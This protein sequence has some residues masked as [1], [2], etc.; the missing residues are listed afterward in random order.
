MRGDVGIAPYEENCMQNAKLQF[1][2]QT[3]KTPVTVPVTGVRY[4]ISVR[5]CA[6]VIPMIR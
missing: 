5:Y 6:G 4:S 1:D 3:P 2:F